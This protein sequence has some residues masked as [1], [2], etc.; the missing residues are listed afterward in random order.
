M[1]SKQ[2]AS[3]RLASSVGYMGPPTA[4]RV[5]SQNSVN[6][7]LCSKLNNTEAKLARVP[8]CFVVVTVLLNFLPIPD[9]NS[10]HVVK[11][12]FTIFIV[13]L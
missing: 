3:Y 8:H 13:T 7:C 1:T 10:H 2:S 9:D 11:I 12:I 6:I 4:P 5:Q